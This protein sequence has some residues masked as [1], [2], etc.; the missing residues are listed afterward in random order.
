MLIN[1]VDPDLLTKA[2][3]FQRDGASPH[4]GKKVIEYLDKVFAGREIGRRGTIECP[5]GS[6][7]LT[8]SEYFL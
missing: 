5:P 6:S 3:L 7:D 8:L 2:L 1:D 4:F